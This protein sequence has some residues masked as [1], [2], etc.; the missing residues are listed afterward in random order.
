MS[1]Y[2]KSWKGSQRSYV[3]ALG[4][5][6]VERRPFKSAPVEVE[7]KVVCETAKDVEDLKSALDVLAKDGDKATGVVNQI[8]AMRYECPEKEHVDAV[9]IEL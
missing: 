6:N 1:L 5:G 2:V 9:W 8:D 4:G 7:F 3:V